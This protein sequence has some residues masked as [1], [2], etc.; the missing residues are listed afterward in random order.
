MQFSA[1]H[2]SCIYQT[3]DKN[4][5]SIIKDARL[6]KPNLIAVPCELWNM[7]AMRLLG[8]PAVSPIMTEYDWPGRYTPFIHQ[9][10][11]A[12]FLTLHP[13]AFNFAAIGCGKTLATLWAADYLMSKG[14]I[15]RCLVLS[16]LSTLK[17]VW[18]DEIFT[19]FLARRSCVILHGTRQQRLSRLAT[20]HDFYIINHDGLGVGGSRVHNSLSLGELAE[21]IMERNDIDC[22]IVDEGSVYKESGTQRSRTLRKVVAQKPYVWWLTG[23][24][25]PNDPVDAWNQARTVRKD[26]TESQMAFRDR[27]MMRVSTFKWVERPEAMKITAE[28]LQP[29]YRISREECIDLPPCM[30]MDRDVEMTPAQHKAFKELK[31][32]AAT[33]IGGGQINAVNEAVLR[34]KLI[35]VAC[36]ALYDNQHEVHKVDAAPRLKVLRE[37]IE[38]A[39]HKILIFAPLTSVVNL[40]YDELKSTYT[41]ERINGEVSRGKR[42]EVFAAFQQQDSPRI[43]VA[44]PRTMAH[45]LTLTRAATIVWYGP[46][47]QP[48]IYTQANGRINRPGQ[49]NNMLVV[50][51]SSTPIE[52]EIFKRLDKKETMQGIIL[53]LVQGEIDDE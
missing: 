21:T 45:G 51:L 41:V 31:T 6:V 33:I 13:R 44:D 5:L 37:V 9:R 46:T 16:P 34:M 7:Q 12:S 19:H 17:R 2:N 27:T 49:V 25:T 15:H 1:T 35:Q 4:V 10:H 8:Y 28:V 40:I 53:K 42:E 47:D 30:V 48:E 52:R 23:T 14:V 36:G 18:E 20:P 38:E 43:I 50:R 11:M 39:S 32:Q 26:Y 3:N 22:V 24:P 29:A